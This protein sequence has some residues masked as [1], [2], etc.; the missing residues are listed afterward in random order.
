[1]FHV[2]H[3]SAS[4]TP[5]R[6]FDE[7]RYAIEAGLISPHEVRCYVLPWE[8][9]TPSS[10]VSRSSKRYH[11]HEDAYA[12]DANKENVEA[13]C[14]RIFA[15]S[16]PTTPLAQPEPPRVAEALVESTYR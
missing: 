2:L 14:V 3:D 4:T 16:T 13:W 8:N 11:D 10:N 1:M 5:T 7:Y 6:S 9:A 12:D 15:K